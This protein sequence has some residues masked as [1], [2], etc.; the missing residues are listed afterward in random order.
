MSDQPYIPPIG[1]RQHSTDWFCSTAADIIGD[2]GQRRS[3]YGDALQSFEDIATLWSVVLKVPVS[4]E[5]V[6]LCQALLKMGR[7]INK[8]NHVDSWVDGIGY[9][10]LGGAISQT[11]GRH[12]SFGDMQ[13]GETQR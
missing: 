6:A 9:F 11:P 4:A 3:D 5:Q 12:P 2:S 13:K 1:P 10:A 7:L 8:P